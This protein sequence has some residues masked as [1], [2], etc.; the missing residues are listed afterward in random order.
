MRGAK[1][2]SRKENSMVVR[3]RGN[4]WYY[5]FM[6]RGKRYRE[7]IPD[8]RTKQEAKDIEAEAR[9]LVRQGK[10][11]PLLAPRLETFIEE[12]YLPWAKT[13]KRSFRNDAW[14]CAVLNEYFGHLRLNEITVWLVEKFKSERL[15]GETRLGKT[16]T[17]ASVN[18]ELDLLSR[19]LSMACDQDL[20]T[21][22][23]LRKV[24]R[25]REDNARE[26][27][28]S[29]SEEARLMA[30]LERTRS[31]LRAMVIVAL[32]TGMRR[33]EIHR[34]TWADVDFDRGI[35]LVRKTKTGRD[36]IVPMHNLVERLMKELSQAAQLREKAIQINNRSFSIEVEICDNRI[37]EIDWIEKLWRKTCKRAGITNLRFHDLR[38]TFATRLAAKGVDA[39]AI[40]RLLGHATVNMTAL[41]VN[42]T[43]EH[44]QAAINK[45]DSSLSQI[46]PKPEEQRKMRIR[47]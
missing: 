38:H 43:S 3:R 10:Y 34:L 8:A 45:L 30:V 12:V 14:R 28:L 13:N 25:L 18:R 39:F 33:G 44:L 11:V 2:V 7:A 1:A 31:P 5:D 21:N 20:L 6:V 40:A 36:R 16:R 37:F 47:K 22:N 35:I 42:S 41:Y 27:V 9:R 23:C 15:K 29:V 32:H 24:K 46:C 4:I 17:P 19:I 26:R